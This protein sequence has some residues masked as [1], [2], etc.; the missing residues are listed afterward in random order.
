[1]VHIPVLL[2]KAIDFLRCEPGRVYVDVTLGDG[3]HAEAILEKSSPSGILIGIDRDGDSI[4]YAQERLSLYQKRTILFHENF[5]NIKNV[6]T[7][8]AEFPKLAPLC[9][10]TG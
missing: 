5:R 4:K 3:G 10:K 8:R 6:V 1:M 9:L 7:A 2:D